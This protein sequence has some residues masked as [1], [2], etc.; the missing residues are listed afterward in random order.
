MK[1]ILVIITLV[2]LLIGF[3]GFRAQ[4]DRGSIPFRPQV[5]IYEPLQQ[6]IIAWNGGEQILIL[7]TDLYASE[8]T[9]VLEVIP[10]PAE[11]EVT[12]AD[13]E[14]FQKVHDLYAEELYQTFTS[15]R[16][17]GGSGAGAVEPA[18]E[19]TFHEKIGAH[20]ISVTR[21]NRSDDFV[22]WV[23][24]YLTSQ[25]VDNPTIPDALAD[26][27]VEYIED[28]FDWFVFSVVE[29]TE[30]PNSQEA[31]QYR[32]ESDAVYFPLKIT[33]TE[34]GST[35]LEIMAFMPPKQIEREAS[36]TLNFL[37]TNVPVTVENSEIIK[38]NEEMGQMMSNYDISGLHHWY[39][40][41]EL[42]EF[43]E[44]L[45]VTVPNPSKDELVYYQDMPYYNIRPSE[46]AENISLKEELVDLE[47]EVI[48]GE[49][50]VKPLS[51]ETFL[52][53]PFIGDAILLSPYTGRTVVGYQKLVDS[54]LSLRGYYI[55]EIEFD[56]LDL[57]G[58]PD[59]FEREIRFGMMGDD[60]RYFNLPAFYLTDVEGFEQICGEAL[61]LESGSFMNS[62][63]CFWYPEE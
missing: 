49:I 53:G 56:L 57:T 23:N 42:S 60:N 8:E 33:R 12:E 25:G 27:I 9:K 20:D 28:G 21:V 26:V 17:S 62:S 6:A 50:E 31:I 24:E 30:E 13:P 44:D 22:S 45:V 1:K 47:E 36:R 2:F 29:L 46:M 51:D 40:K 34:T 48:K 19:V 52:T 32:F 39:I 55:D 59:F 38:I 58:L 10:L 35:E 18:G 3:A 11:P 37:P 54:E 7:S 41:G 63:N 5:R 15:L 4:A 61:Y 16:R 43:K 14:I